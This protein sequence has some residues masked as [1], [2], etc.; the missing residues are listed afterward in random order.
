MNK[1]DEYLKRLIKE[2]DTEKVNHTFGC[3]IETSSGDGSHN[4][5]R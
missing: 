4:E 3:R 5:R 1:Q 2:G